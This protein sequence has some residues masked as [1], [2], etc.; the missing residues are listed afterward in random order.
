MTIHTRI[1]LADRELEV[2]KRCLI[3]IRQL[4][5]PPR[6]SGDQESQDLPHSKLW[7]TDGFPKSS[8]V[9][10]ILLLRMRN[11]SKALKRVSATYLMKRATLSGSPFPGH[12]FYDASFLFENEIYI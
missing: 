7:S 9:N 1:L 5:I 10:I 6:A 12:I 8:S 11:Q 4:T 3:A 2:H